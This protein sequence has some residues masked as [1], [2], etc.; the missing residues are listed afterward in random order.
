MKKGKSKE[1]RTVE[2][3]KKKGRPYANGS[4]RSITKRARMTEE[5]VKKLKYCCEKLGKTESDV[6]RLG[7]ETIY[8]KVTG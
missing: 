7:I 4:E 5:D 1:A 2:A 6:I 3:V 8:Q